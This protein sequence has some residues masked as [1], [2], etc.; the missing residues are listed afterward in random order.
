MKT[1][2]VKKVTR[3]GM[4]LDGGT[5]IIEINGKNEYFLDNSIHSVTRGKWY[6]SELQKSDEWIWI[7]N[8]EEF[9][10]GMSE[11]IRNSNYKEKNFEHWDWKKSFF[12]LMNNKNKIKRK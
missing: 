11:V 2:D 7:E 9:N 5:L 1:K 10:N 6:K 3:V 8:Q 4:F 12:D